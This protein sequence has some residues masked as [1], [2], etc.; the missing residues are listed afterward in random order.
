MFVY[1]LLGMF[2]T[3]LVLL[4]T[5]V[6]FFFVFALNEEQPKPQAHDDGPIARNIA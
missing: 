5:Q 4:L 2:Q 1:N 6:F 3:M